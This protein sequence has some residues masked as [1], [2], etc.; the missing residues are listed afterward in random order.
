MSPSEAENKEIARK[1][2]V[3]VVT[4]GNLDVVDDI[5]AADHVQHNSAASE[6]L[7]GPDD[8]KDNVSTL[9]RAFPDAECVVED[10]IAEGDMVVRPD[11]ATCTHE[12]EFMGIEATGK[13]IVIGGIHIHRIEDGQIVETWSQGDMMGAMQQ[14]GVVEPPGG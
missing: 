2:A 8:V 9:R 10:M 3:E 4:E 13:E 11:R 14:L 5:I 7:H 1:Y 6:P 12:G